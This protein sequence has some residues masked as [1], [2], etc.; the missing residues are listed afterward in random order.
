MDDDAH[1]SG[2]GYP[3]PRPWP[4]SVERTQQIP[5]VRPDGRDR[6]SASPPGGPRSWVPTQAGN[7][8]T[9]RLQPPNGGERPRPRPAPHPRPAPTPPRPL[10]PRSQ[11]PQSPAGSK[12]SPRPPAGADESSPPDTALDHRPANTTEPV[13]VGLQSSGSP[14]A[15]LPDDGPHDDGPPSDKP[16]AVAAPGSPRD[17]PALDETA[18]IGTG[19][20]GLDPI[21][22]PADAVRSER[23]P[24][25]DTD[26]EP[27]PDTVEPPARFGRALLAAAA[28]TIAP[29]SGHLMLGHRRSGAA[30]LGVFLAG[31]AAVV[32]LL[33]TVPRANLIQTVLSSRS[34]IIGAAV[35]MVAALAWIGVIIRTYLIGRPAAL[36]PGRRAIGALTVCCLCLLV[37]AP[38]GYGANVANSQRNLLETLFRGGDGGTPAAEAIAKPRLNILLVGSDAGPDRTGARTDTMMVA[39]IDTRTGRTTLFGLPRNIGYAQFPAGIAD[40]REVPQGLPRPRPTRTSGD[41]LLNAVYAWGHQHPERADRPPPRPGPEPAAPDG[42]ATCSARLDYYVEVNMAGFASIIDALGGVTVDVG[43]EPLAHRRRPARRA[44]RPAQRL[45]A[46]GVQHLDGDQALAFARSRTRL[47]DYARMGRQRCLLQSILQQ[48]SPT[49]VHDQLPRTSPRPPATASPPTSRRRCCRRWPPWPG[50]TR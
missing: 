49:D 1:T 18:V 24:P 46:P 50:R 40:G 13:I 7:L 6:G 34:L 20:R 12:P 47:R 48:K 17:E 39:S 28:A 16:T 8:P 25:T 45:R 9:S 30:I 41:Y 4:R 32:A 10:P 42:R 31:L 44:A 21:A 22:D 27:W 37:A 29:G 33:L 26:W 11:P 14:S 15:G 36:D 19:S 35:C 3:T 23:I 5:V 38:L 43:P 2:T